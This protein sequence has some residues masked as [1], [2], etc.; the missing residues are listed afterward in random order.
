[1]YGMYKRKYGNSNL[2]IRKE[3]AAKVKR[4]LF[5][6]NGYDE[7]RGKLYHNFTQIVSTDNCTRKKLRLTTK[8]SINLLQ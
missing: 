6:K 8:N 1:M 3:K 5:T 4:S 7:L 2:F